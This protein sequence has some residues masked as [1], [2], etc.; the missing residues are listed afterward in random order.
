MVDLL[1]VNERNTVTTTVDQVKPNF[2]NCQTNFEAINTAL[3]NLPGTGN[4][5]SSVPLTTD[6]IVIG[7]GGEDIKVASGVASPSEG[8]I[9]LQNTGGSEFS[10]LLVSGSS[11]DFIGLNASESGAFVEFQNFEALRFTN[12]SAVAT[13]FATNVGYTADTPVFE[14]NNTGTNGGLVAVYITNINPVGNVVGAPGDLC[15]VDQNDNSRI[16]IH[17]GTNSDNQD[18]AFCVT[19]ADIDLNHRTR[20]A[21]TTSTDTTTLGGGGQRGIYAC[22]D[23]SAERTLTLTTAS[24]TGATA[25]SPWLFAVKDESGNA[26]VNNIIITTEGS[27]TI[28]GAAS[29]AITADYGIATLYS[30]GTNVFSR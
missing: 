5:T 6:L 25:S 1:P 27:E 19:T 29:I 11:E 15:L 28:D 22:T 30:N 10:A 13:A 4:V 12:D 7:N 3:E 21:F 8:G 24:I 26:S 20:A 14:W 17:V 2:D 16:Y 23:T 18:W 9:V